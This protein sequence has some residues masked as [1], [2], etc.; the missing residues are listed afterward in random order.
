MVDRGMQQVKLAIAAE[1]EQVAAF[2]SELAAQEAESRAIGGTVLGASFRDVKAKFYDI[3]IRTDVGSVDVS[4]AQKEDA[5]DDLKRLNLS[6]QREFKQLRDEFKGILLDEGPG[7]PGQPASVPAPGA[8]P[9]SGAGGTGGAGGAGTAGAGSPDKGGGDARIKPGSDAPA[10][11]PTPTVR[12]D[13]EQGKG[14]PASGAPKAGTPAVA[15][16]AGTPS[17]APKAGTPATAPK[18][19]TPAVAPKP[20]TPAAAPKPGTPTAAPKPGTPTPAPKAGTP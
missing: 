3:V 5:D 16:K 19:T 1:R 7:K 14:P 4:W 12:P 10:K 2:Q 8:G 13:N 9:D 18:T 6:R 15:P 11:T 20:G 17:G